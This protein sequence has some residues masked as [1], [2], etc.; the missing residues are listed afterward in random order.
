MHVA[1]RP[2]VCVC[3]HITCRATDNTTTAQHAQVES[4]IFQDL[5]RVPAPLGTFV[6]TAALFRDLPLAD[7]LSAMPLLQPLLEHDVDEAAYR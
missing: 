6:H 4:P 2:P 1:A 5:P 7:R 3:V